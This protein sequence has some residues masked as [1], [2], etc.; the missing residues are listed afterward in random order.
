MVVVYLHIEEILRVPRLG[1]LF[2][3][4]ILT[5]PTDYEKISEKPIPDKSRGRDH[6]D[7][8][9]HEKRDCKGYPHEVR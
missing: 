8:L 2:L 3:K 7:N 6:A 1:I 4:M 5:K 9:G